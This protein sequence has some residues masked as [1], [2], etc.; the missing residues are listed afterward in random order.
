MKPFR[1]A[2]PTPSEHDLQA[3]ILL[4]LAWDP[5]VAWAHRF[6]TGAHVVIGQKQDGTPSRR[7]VRYAFTGCA[8]LLG[9]LTTG[10]L[11]AIE[12][13]RA[14]GKARAEQ[15]IFL[16]Q[17]RDAGGLALLARSIADVQDGIDHFT[18]ARWTWGGGLTRDP[19]PT[20][21][22]ALSAPERA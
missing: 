8:D 21:S 7:F 5:R 20:P 13:K 14:G 11:L 3:A 12:C 10:Q 19:G 6:N 18:G 22:G 1:L 2:H 16:Q 15:K 4:Y 17:V 9:Q